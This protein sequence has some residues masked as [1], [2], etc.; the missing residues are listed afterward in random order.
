MFRIKGPDNFYILSDQGMIVLHSNPLPLS[1]SLC[2]SL[3]KRCRQ[4]ADGNTYREQSLT[5]ISEFENNTGKG[6]KVFF[7]T[8]TSSWI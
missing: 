7:P 5:L 3:I 4:A 1:L 8:F 2:F 6:T